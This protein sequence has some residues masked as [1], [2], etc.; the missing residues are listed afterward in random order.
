[1]LMNAYAGTVEAVAEPADYFETD[2]EGLL[3]IPNERPGLF[4]ILLGTYIVAMFA[5]NY[6]PYNDLL[7]TIGLV[8]PLM[9]LV[10]LISSRYHFQREFAAYVLFSMWI[11]ASA[12]VSEYRPLAIRGAFFVLKIQFLAIVVALRCSSFSRMRAYLIAVGVGT[13]FLTVPALLSA[14]YMAFDARLA[15]GVGDPNA[16]GAVAVCSLAAWSFL[17]FMRGGWI[18]LLVCPVM[19]AATLYLIMLTASRGALVATVVFAAGGAWYVWRQGGP[20][21]KLVLAAALPIAVVAVFYAFRNMLIIERFARLFAALGFETALASGRG[22]TSSR[23]DVIRDA[24]EVFYQH[25]VMGAGYGTLRMYSPWVYSHTTPF[26]LLYATGLVGTVLYYFIVFS[27]WR[28]L[29]QAKKLAAGDPEIVSRVSMCRLLIV[30]QLVAS[31]SLPVEQSRFHAVLFGTW[32]GV[33]WR[34]RAWA[35][36]QAAEAQYAEEGLED[37]VELA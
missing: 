7:S 27:A 4:D 2:S 17:L 36:Q 3:E 6:S 9:V 25:P 31:M 35:K 23:I 29:G 33:T 1:L 19:I 10:S 21:T 26:D 15:G 14:R 5:T 24:L 16:L 28:A 18:K 12:Y 37:A 22:A 13:A 34:L 32:L 11:M 20:R 30:T 8:I